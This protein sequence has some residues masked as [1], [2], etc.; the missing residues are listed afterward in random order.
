MAPKW[1]LQI[2]GQSTMQGLWLRDKQQKQAGHLGEPLLN[3]QPHQL[4]KP[5]PEISGEFLPL[6]KD[7]MQPRG[8]QACQ[9]VLGT[10]LVGFPGRWPGQIAQGILRL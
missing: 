9:Q 1:N 8:T 5:L 7:N 4:E 10:L 6:C 2:L 3:I